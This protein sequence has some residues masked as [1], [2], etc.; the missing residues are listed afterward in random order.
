MVGVA[1]RLDARVII[2]TIVFFF[3]VFVVVV[4]YGS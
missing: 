4:V 3:D 1:T 2:L